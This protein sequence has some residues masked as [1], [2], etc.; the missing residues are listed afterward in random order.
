MIF[1]SMCNSV[2]DWYI[3]HIIVC[4]I[5]WYILTS[6]CGGGKV[7]WSIMPETFFCFRK[8]FPSAE[9]KTMLDIDGSWRGANI[10]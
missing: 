3:F 6:K 8:V 10:V 4:R 5:G 2:Q 7:T 9:K 1:L